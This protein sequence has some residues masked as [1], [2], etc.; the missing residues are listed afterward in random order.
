MRRVPAFVAILLACSI[1]HS[2]QW[3]K[4]QEPGVPRDAERRVSM[5]APAPRTA[6]GKPDFTGDWTRAD[7]DP[8]VPELAGILTLR[9]GTRGVVV[10]PFS[11]S[12]WFVVGGREFPS[13]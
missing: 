2:A 9:D 10:E 12:W 7:R 5:D 3:P 13:P 6:D 4:Y 8:P 11:S 1:S